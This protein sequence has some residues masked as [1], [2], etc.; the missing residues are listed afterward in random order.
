MAAAGEIK[1]AGFRRK[2]PL[3]LWSHG[4]LFQ[5]GRILKYIQGKKKK[6]LFYGTL[7]IGIRHL[8][9]MFGVNCFIMF[10]FFLF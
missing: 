9:L 3:K 6:H 7:V 5:T 10:F 1:L 8:N 2:P 4:F